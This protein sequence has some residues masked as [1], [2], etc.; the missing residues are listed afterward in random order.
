MCKAPNTGLSLVYLKCKRARKESCLVIVLVQGP[1]DSDAE[2]RV[3]VQVVCLGH[4]G[5]IS[6]KAG[7]G[8]VKKV[9]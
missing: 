9:K 5:D 3:Q 7:K 8:L 2:M 4:P 1:P 6:R